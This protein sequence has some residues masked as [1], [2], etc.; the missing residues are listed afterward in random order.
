M[1]S[2]ATAFRQ[3]ADRG[4]RYQASLARAGGRGTGLVGLEGPFY[5]PRPLAS[6]KRHAGGE[7][8]Q[9]GVA[10]RQR[11]R[12]G[13]VRLFN[14]EPYKLHSYSHRPDNRVKGLKFHLT[15]DA[16]MVDIKGAHFRAREVSPL[17]WNAAPASTFYLSE[18]P[19]GLQQRAGSTRFV[20]HTRPFPVPF[21]ALVRR[22]SES[23]LPVI[24]APTRPAKFQ[25]SIDRRLLGTPPVSWSVATAL[26]LAT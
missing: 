6:P 17:T 12:A 3:T 9:H 22:T 18:R 1:P 8:C 11:K 13:K 26:R 10:K 25:V 2:F 16:L 24:G 23:E 19:S 15:P 14:L 5:N 20:G 4:G 21:R 7:A